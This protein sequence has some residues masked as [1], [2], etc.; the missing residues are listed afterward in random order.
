MAI[1]KSR[2]IG[3][4]IAQ[5][6]CRCKSRN[7]A[8]FQ[9]FLSR[10]EDTKSERGRK[11]QT[12][13]RRKASRTTLGRLNASQ[14]A[15]LPIQHAG[16]WTGSGAYP[17]G[18]RLRD[19]GTRLL[20]RGLGQSESGRRCSEKREGVHCATVPFRC[21]CFL[22]AVGMACLQQAWLASWL[23]GWAWPLS[24]PLSQ[25]WLGRV[26]MN[27]SLHLQAH[28]LAAM[29]TALTVRRQV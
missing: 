2:L 18:E 21:A 8:R 20:G 13:G 16:H 26:Q 27:P 14:P 17:A 4:L 6:V 24:C 7:L 5:P 29:A 15:Q 28:R 9:R 10:T 23:A 12:H 3:R 22:Q 19:P 1:V 25:V 11:R